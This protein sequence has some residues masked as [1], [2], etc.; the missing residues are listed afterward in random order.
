M[1]ASACAC[2]RAWL[3]C[4]LMFAFMD[5]M[6]IYVVCMS[7]GCVCLCMCVSVRELCASTV[8]FY[9]CFVLR[10]CVK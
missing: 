8:F 1:C 4:V 3:E 6:C 2:M 9:V 10:V 7:C 5:V